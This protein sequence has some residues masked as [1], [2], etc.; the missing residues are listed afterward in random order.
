MSIITYANL[1]TPVT[2]ADLRVPVKALFLAGEKGVVYDLTDKRTLYQ[3]SART[4][5]V[6]A[7]GN[8]I[9]SVSDLSGNGKHASQGTSTSRPTF[10]G[11][12]TFDGVDDWLITASIDFTATDAITVVAGVRKVSD[13]AS[14]SVASLGGG[15]SAGTFDLRGP[16]SSAANNFSNSC[17]SG[18]LSESIAAGFTAPISAVLTASMDI[19]SDTNR[20]RVNGVLSGDPTTDIGAGNFTNNPVYLGSRNGSTMHFNGLIYR[21]L[22]IGRALTTDE[23]A[24][25]EAWAAEGAGIAL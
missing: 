11:G 9:G 5:L 21:L 15:S 13:V 14:A 24:A 25:A 22:V 20:L 18:N 19:S 16:R 8:P 7:N 2:E 17:R 1:A 23:R 4:T 6:A 12:A 10:Q 3:D